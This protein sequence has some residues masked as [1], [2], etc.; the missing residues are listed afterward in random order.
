MPVERI[1]LE[2][3]ARGEVKLLTYLAECRS[4]GGHSGSPTFWY[5]ELHFSE[6]IKIGRQEKTVLVAKDYLINLIG[7]VT[8]HYDIPQ[9]GHTPSGLDVETNINAGIAIIT[10]TDNIRE[11]L[12]RSDLRDEREQRFKQMQKQPRSNA[13]LD[14]GTARPI[15]QET[16][17]GFTIP[18]PTKGE[19]LDVFKKVTRKRKPS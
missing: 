12:M 17:K 13:V 16:R 18:V 9:S 3:K 4:W 5:K 15:G 8:G 2:T 19:V 11:L 6:K 7:L 14:I 10:P 1:A